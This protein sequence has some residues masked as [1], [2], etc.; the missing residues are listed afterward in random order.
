MIW[1]G[2]ID[3]TI[4]VPFVLTSMTYC[5]LLESVLLPWLEDLPFSSRRKVIFMHDNASHSAKATIRASWFP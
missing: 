3:N 4:V 1:A 2:I 5:D